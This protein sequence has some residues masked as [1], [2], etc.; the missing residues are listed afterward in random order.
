MD[1]IFHDGVDDDGGGGCGSSMGGCT[2]RVMVVGAIHVTAV[3]IVQLGLSTPT[4]GVVTG[5]AMTAASIGATES[6]L[7]AF[8]GT[9]TKGTDGGP[10]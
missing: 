6:F 7:A 4:S 8:V 10:I 2:V 1:V 3:D 5:G 9:T